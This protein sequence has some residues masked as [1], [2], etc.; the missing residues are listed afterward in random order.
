MENIS[1]S[2]YWTLPADFSGTLPVR[3]YSGYL[4][5][6]QSLSFGLLS[7]PPLSGM[8]GSR[9][10]VKSQCKRLRNNF[11]N[12]PDFHNNLHAVSIKGDQPP[13]LPFSTAWLPLSPPANRSTLII[14]QKRQFAPDASVFEI[15]L[16]SSSYF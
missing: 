5:C 7:P 8:W 2:L 4:F 10:Y 12:T 1:F 15:N 16:P 6:S 3:Q 13:Q 14:K 11:C 9:I